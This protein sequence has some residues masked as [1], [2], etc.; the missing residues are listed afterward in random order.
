MGHEVSATVV[1]YDLKGVSMS[2]RRIIPFVKIVN[3]VASAH[4]P[5]FVDRIILSSAPSIFSFLWKLVKNILDP[6]TREKVKV[7]ST[8]ET[9]KLHEF[10]RT[11]IDPSE[12]PE[13]FGGTSPTVVPMPLHAAKKGIKLP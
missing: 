7:Y 5:E 4:Y 12:L 13:E 10:L 8:G 3:A 1:V 6:V 2:G 9:K 11:Q